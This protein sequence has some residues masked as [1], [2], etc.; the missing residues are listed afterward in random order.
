VTARRGVDLKRHPEARMYLN[1]SP[2][3]M[4]IANLVIKFMFRYNKLVQRSSLHAL[5][6]PEEVQSFFYDL[7]NTGRR[8]GI[9]MPVMSS[10]EPD[11]QKFA[12][13]GGKS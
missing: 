11:I 3:A 7:L 6:D 8:M 2:L 5:G 1:T 10:F 12:N 13:Q 9:E 4:W